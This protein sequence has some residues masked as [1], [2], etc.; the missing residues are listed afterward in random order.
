MMELRLLG[1]IALAVTAAAAD[2]DPR[3]MQ[4]GSLIHE[5][6][7]SD[8]PYCVVTDQPGLLQRERPGVTSL[9]V[10][11]VT[12]N[13][14]AREG[15]AGEHVV[16]VRST[17]HGRSWSDPLALET[18]FS[19]FDNA[20]STIAIT[21]FGRIYVVYNA[22]L[23]HVH[24]LRGKNI[25]R[26]DEL[27]YFVMKYS[28]DAALTWSTE[29]LLVPYRETAI[30]QT[31]SF[32]GKTRI[33]W[34]VDQMKERDGTVYFAFTKIGSYT[35]APPQEGWFMASSNMHTERDASKVEWTLLP[36]GE[37]GPGPIEQHCAWPSNGTDCVAEEW[38]IIP[39][40]HSSGFFAV[41]RTSQGVL[42]ASHTADPAG[43]SG[44]MPSY[45]A[46]HYYG[47]SLKNPRG[48]ITLKRFSNGKYLMLWYN[49]GET[50][51]GNGHGNQDPLNNRMPYWLSAGWESTTAPGTIVFS[52]PE[53]VLYNR[54]AIISSSTAAR[55]GYPDFIEDVDGKVYIT[56]TN[57]QA[58]LCH[59]VDENLLNA[60][61]TQSTA[62]S[63]AKGF[64]L[65]F[66][67]LPP[68]GD[69]GK[70]W[71]LKA[72][73]PM[74]RLDAPY[75]PQLGLTIELW[76]ANHQVARPHT[77]TSVVEVAPSRSVS[78]VVGQK[79]PGPES[80]H[81]YPLVLKLA[82]GR[83]ATANVTLD[84]T[85]ALMLSLPGAHHFAVVLDGGPL[86]VM[87]LVDGQLCDGGVSATRGWHWLLPPIVATAFSDLNAG[88]GGPSTTT[89]ILGKGYKG[90]RRKI[91][92][93]ALFLVMLPRC[94]VWSAC[95]NPIRIR[96]KFL[97]RVTGSLLGGR[98]YPRSL[99]NSEIVSNFRAGP[100]AAKRATSHT[101]E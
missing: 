7:Y 97:A 18:N 50:G 45:P 87:F 2:A 6:D 84:D 41:F 76:L 39:L 15:S 85:C 33:M 27:G 95:F 71:P 69:H 99:L 83:G 29:R 48:P 56:E 51:F 37:H 82:D 13:D 40:A 91:R 32:G 75:S 38:H 28:D 78:V 66:G 34:T 61:W 58:A 64:A 10:C 81:A 49:N 73:D 77:G 24:T 3:D 47:T 93:R 72:Q 80:L 88:P 20:Y 26:V 44:W 96:M 5:W 8:Q 52:A 74:P 42:G 31:N 22:N 65:E 101:S 67:R 54:S 92:L 36:G 55:P 21:P 90:T 46:Q 63:V 59:A 70:P 16:S 19:D 94:P 86:V 89:A 100:P 62:K 57:K 23:G 60:L 68:T 53:I 79:S 4:S 11:A 25:S 35:Q 9:W 17:D 98:I 1:G 12:V 30:D 43:K 14:G